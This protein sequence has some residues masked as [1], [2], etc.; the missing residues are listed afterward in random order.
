MNKEI[1][2]KNVCYCETTK[3]LTLQDT[4]FDH[5]LNFI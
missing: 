3:L 2:L 1:L 4:T 5:I